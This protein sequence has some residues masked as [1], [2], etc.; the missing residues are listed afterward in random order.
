MAYYRTVSISFWND[1]KVADDFTPEDKY[2]FLYCLTN[3]HT[4]ISGCYEISMKQIAQ[5]TGY[6]IDTVSRLLDR[7]EKNHHVVEYDRTTKELLVKHWSR[8]NWAESSKVMVAV[9][10]RVPNIKSQRFRKY[11]EALLS[12]EEIEEDARESESAAEPVPVTVPVTVTDVS[13]G[14]KYPIDAVSGASAAPAS[15]GERKKRFTPPTIEE[16]AQYC[17]ERGN[18]VDA[19]RFVDFYDSNGWK[20]GKNPMKDWKAAVRTWEGRC[21]NQPYRSANNQR[22]TSSADLFIQMDREGVFSDLE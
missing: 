6:N 7:M 5:E 4:D 21:E 2:F 20:V 3:P 14:Y 8:Y 19:Q 10:R 16:V 15:S 1:S 22:G 18:S 9:R 17:N 12:G 13:I 11:I